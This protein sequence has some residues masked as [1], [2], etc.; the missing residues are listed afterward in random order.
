VDKRDAYMKTTLTVWT[1]FYMSH[2]MHEGWECAQTCV[3]H[4]GQSPR[5]LQAAKMLSPT[6]ESD[7][8]RGLIFYSQVLYTLHG[9]TSTLLANHKKQHCISLPPPQHTIK[10]T[11]STKSKNA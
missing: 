10:T 9:L 5:M 11:G 3:L 4:K 2:W 7:T 1:H 6:I 8:Q